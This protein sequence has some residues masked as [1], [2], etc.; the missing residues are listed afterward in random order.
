MPRALGTRCWVLKCHGL[1]APSLQPALLVIPDSACA[2]HVL[3]RVQVACSSR[4]T[5]DTAAAAPRAPLLASAPVPS[6][7][8]AR[9]M[10]PDF[11][12]TMHQLLGVQAARPVRWT[13]DMAAAPMHA[14]SLSFVPARTPQLATSVASDNA[15]GMR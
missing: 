15:H 3:L 7:L 12:C 9:P 5:S 8:L 10:F 11:D 6:L 4:W 13:S 14:P 1:P 2:R